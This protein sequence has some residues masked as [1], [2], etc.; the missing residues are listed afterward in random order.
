MTR[1]WQ[2]V[3][4]A[5]HTLDESHD[6]STASTSQDPSWKLKRN[7]SLS[8]QQTGVAFAL[9]SS[10]ALAVALG[11]AMVGVTYI[12]IFAGLELVALGAAWLIW[13]RHVGDG[14][15]VQLQGQELEVRSV[16]ADRESVT[17][18]PTAWLNIRTDER[19]VWLRTGGKALQ[20]GTLV[21]RGQRDRFVRELRLALK[22]C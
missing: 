1:Q 20:V 2:F 10:L 3:A 22:T 12:L 9:V 4:N 13:G 5:M 7:C 14:E 8:P 16:R 11:F 21:T 15:D 19:G 18:L 6:I 17:R